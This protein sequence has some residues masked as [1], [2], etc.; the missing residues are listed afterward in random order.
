MAGSNQ[1]VVGTA[2]S[3]ATLLAAAPNTVTAGPAGWFSIVNGGTI[4]YYGGGTAVTQ[5]SGVPLAANATLTGFLFPGDQIYAVT[6][7]GSSTVS[8]FQ[9]GA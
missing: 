8:V 3:A 5:N 9:A 6:I 1:Y 2:A 4:I 7:S